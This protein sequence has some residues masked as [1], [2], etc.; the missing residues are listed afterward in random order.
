MRAMIGQWVGMKNVL[1]IAAIVFFGAVMA[2]SISESKS[3]ADDTDAP[4]VDKKIEYSDELLIQLAVS[5]LDRSMKFYGDILELKQVV[6]DPDLEWAKYD[7][8]VR[9]VRIG[10]GRQDVVSGSGT[11]S[12]NIG[13]KNVEAAKRL[14]ESRG[15]QFPRPIINIPGVVKLADFTDPDGNRFRLAGPPDPEAKQNAQPVIE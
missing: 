6:H 10:I 4:A 1:F 3:A 14:L 7:T 5:D 2:G 11:I 12:I 15:V 13:V 9:G 8:N